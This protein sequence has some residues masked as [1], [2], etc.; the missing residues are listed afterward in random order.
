[1]TNK[2][3]IEVLTAEIKRWKRAED[4][5]RQGSNWQKELIDIIDA[6]SLAIE[7]LKKEEINE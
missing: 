2:R 1:M 3:A 4:K 6:M 7:A 5:F